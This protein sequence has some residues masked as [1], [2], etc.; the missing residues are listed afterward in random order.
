MHKKQNN[1]KT[2]KN[3]KMKNARN[4]ILTHLSALCACLRYGLVVP[5]KVSVYAP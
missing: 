5:T 2:S 3:G 1:L 4:S